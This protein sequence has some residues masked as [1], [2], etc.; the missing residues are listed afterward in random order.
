MEKI[1]K[2]KEIEMEKYGQN[3]K[4]AEKNR[5]VKIEKKTFLPL[6]IDYSP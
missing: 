4:K 2:K 3:L 5:N 6:E 1:S